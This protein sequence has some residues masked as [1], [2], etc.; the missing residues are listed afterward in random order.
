M[1][2]QTASLDLWLVVLLLLLCVV[3]A[4]AVVVLIPV[5][6]HPLA[7]VPVGI[8]CWFLCRQEQVK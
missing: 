6:F 4:V 2:K 1:N 8:V 7:L 5:V 3:I